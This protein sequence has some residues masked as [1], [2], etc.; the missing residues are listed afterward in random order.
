MTLETLYNCAIVL[1]WLVIK[2]VQYKQRQEASVWTNSSQEQALNMHQ[3][4]KTDSLICWHFDFNDQKVLVTACYFSIFFT[5]R[6]WRLNQV[7][8]RTYFVDTHC[9]DLDWEPVRIKIPEQYAK[10]CCLNRHKIVSISPNQH[11][12]QAGQMIIK[13]FLHCSA[14]ISW[15]CH[16]F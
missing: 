13:L 12:S 4:P 5:R 3:F 10:P 1:S 6:I 2:A 15:W 11:F 16:S 8:H 7:F 14:I 9:S